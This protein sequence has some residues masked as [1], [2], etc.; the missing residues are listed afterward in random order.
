MPV[1]VMTDKVVAIYSPEPMTDCLMGSGFCVGGGLV[2]SADHTIRNQNGKVLSGIYGSVLI[3]D[4]PVPLALEY[5]DSFP[6][7]DVAVLRIRDGVDPMSLPFF[8]LPSERGGYQAGDEVCL[9]GFPGAFSDRKGNPRPSAF[10]MRRKG[11]IAS[12]YESMGD[13]RVLILDL[14]GVA[15]FSGSPVVHLTSGQAIAT[16]SK[17]PGGEGNTG[18]SLAFPIEQ[19]DLSDL[20]G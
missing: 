7:R 20:H 11:I 9:C 3:A 5:V 10:P 1:F 4:K 18:F 15:G 6:G 2:L 13:T 12:V 8:D 19:R 14:L 16:F 17:M